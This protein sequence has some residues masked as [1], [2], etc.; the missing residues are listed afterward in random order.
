MKMQQ[1]TVIT[2]LIIVLCLAI[3]CCSPAFGLEPIVFPDVKHR[4]LETMEVKESSDF[5]SKPNQQDRNLEVERT[6]YH[7]NRMESILNSNRL[8]SELNEDLKGQFK[9]WLADMI[10]RGI[11]T[12]NDERL[13]NLHWLREDVESNE[14]EIQHEV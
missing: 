4:R 11:I 3:V 6:R 9:I 14:D 1:S 8:D 10:E 12:R 13:G 2:Y 7:E 5:V